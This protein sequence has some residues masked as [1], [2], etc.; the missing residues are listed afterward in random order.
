[1]PKSFLPWLRLIFPFSITY[2]IITFLTRIG[3]LV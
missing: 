2:L 1:M 3:L